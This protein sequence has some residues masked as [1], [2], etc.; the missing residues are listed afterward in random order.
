MQVKFRVRN[1]KAV[2]DFLKSVPRGA[3]PVALKAFAEYVLGNDRHGL[4]HNEPY[5]Y[6]SRKAAY[7]VTFFTAKQRR[8]FFAAVRDGRI[9]P[10]QNN[11]TGETSAAWQAEPRNN[12]YR[13]TM[14]NNTPGGYYT[15]DNRGQA[16]Q[17]A[18]VGW[19]KIRDVLVANYQGA[20][21]AAVLAVNRYL[22]S[23]N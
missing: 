15:R 19:R 14:T 13:Y 22:Q 18:K 23:K 20:V 1:V 7:G 6:V 10:G 12:G 11:R 4:R 3:V 16:R 5:K 8:W 17:L 21:R 9:N 2:Q